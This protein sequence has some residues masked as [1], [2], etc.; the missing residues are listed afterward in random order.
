MR[1]GGRLY[2]ARA[3]RPTGPA[4]RVTPLPSESMRIGSVDIPTL[5]RL[6]PMAG[7]TNAPFRLVARECGSGSPPPRRWTPPRCS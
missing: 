5:A 4:A 1:T 3:A 2:A 7:A 6:A